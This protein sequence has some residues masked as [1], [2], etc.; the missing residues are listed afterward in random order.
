MSSITH[1]TPEVEVKRSSPHDALYAIVAQ[2]NEAHKVGE[3]V[4]V[5][6]LSEGDAKI[7]LLENGRAVASWSRTDPNAERHLRTLLGGA[8]KAGNLRPPLGSS[9]E[10]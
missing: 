6:A 9:C 1:S 4:S 2:W 10:P 3:Q 7:S 8:T 5:F